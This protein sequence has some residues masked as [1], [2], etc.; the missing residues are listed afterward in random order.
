MTFKKYLYLLASIIFGGLFTGAMGYLVQGQAFGYGNVTI[1][2]VTPAFFFGVSVAT[3]ILYLVSN[4][5]A[6]LRAA[7]DHLEIEIKNRTGEL[8]QSE[9]RFRNFAEAAYDWF[10]ETDEN[11][12]IS[13]M[14][15]LYCERI[16]VPVERLIGKTI[17]DVPPQDVDPEIWSS[18][19]SKF[20]AHEELRDI[21]QPRVLRNGDVIWISVN[22]KPVYDV[23]GDFKGYR[24]TANEITERVI[25]EQALR[26]REERFSRSQKYANIG[27]WELNIQTEELIWSDH[28]SSLFGHDESP[29]EPSHQNF[30]NAVHPD[31][32]QKLADAVRESV[33][34]GAD[35][36]VEIRII[37]PDGSVHWIS[38]VGEVERQED[39]TPIRM[40]G[41]T[42]DITE[43]KRI[44]K[45][46]QENQNL[47]RVFLDSTIDYSALVDKDGRFVFVNEAM[48]AVY[49]TSRDD[50]IGRPMFR[51]PLS[52]FGEIR[53]KRFDDVLGSGQPIRAIEE[54]EGR[55]YDNS[56][57]PVFDEV[58]NASSVAIFVREITELKETE[59]KLRQLSRA[60]EQAPNA[61]FITD[62]EGTIQFVNSMFTTL[63]GYTAD[64]AIGN[65]SSILKSGHTS[66]ET[67]AELWGAIK[68]GKEWRG[69]IKDRRKDGSHFWAN[70]TIGPVKDENGIITHFVATHEDITHRKE[71]EI[72]MQEAMEQAEIANRAK[73]DMLANMSHE[74]RT[75]LNAII[76]FA[77]SIMAETFGPIGNEKYLE[78]IG[79]IGNSG[80]HLLELINDILDVS[81]IEVGKLDLREE[82]I[83]VDDLVESSVRLIS[84]R[85]KQKQIRLKT[86]IQK[87]LPLIYADARRLKQILL[88]LLSNA[89]KFTPEEGTVTLTVSHEDDGGH[90]FIVAD[91][92]I[93]MNLVELAKAMTQFGQVDSGLSRKEEGSGLGLPLTTGLV[94][95]HGGTLDIVSEKGIGTTVTVKFTKERV[96]QDV[97]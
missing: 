45:S 66:Q 93:G 17:A 60:V 64:E 19:E 97:G 30:I 16:G 43:R 82:N 65:N 29:L 12:Q 96:V 41:V 20:V 27:T 25:A 47:L 39:G 92:G 22:G 58:G 3:I 51:P 2:A 11:H 38:E 23:S 74:L 52:E 73:S 57:F 14:S 50:L 48:A 62:T 36:Y 77:G 94:E 87:A 70:E 86:N 79:D 69:E 90:V 55:W 37:W 34:N 72:T 15:D 44:E 89:V 49:E 33:E 1:L 26:E 35:Y 88:N 83:I 13:F 7:K 31:D 59:K 81:A 91:T 10:W 53:Q 76:G 80:G 78:Y 95:L 67:Y 84:F 85:A 18:F 32:R 63:T 61:V 68:A 21:I 5:Q 24:G 54:Q 9:Q 28:V 8:I 4:S 46:L 56:Y 42:N 6:K 75:P 40:L 71:A